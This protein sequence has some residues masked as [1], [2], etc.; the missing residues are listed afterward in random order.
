MISEQGAQ[1]VLHQGRQ[2]LGGDDRQGCARCAAPEQIG[3]GHAEA[4]P[5]LLDLMLDVTEEGGPVEA[6]RLSLLPDGFPPV[7]GLEDSL[8]LDYKRAI[9][10]LRGQADDESTEHVAA[11][12]GVLVGH[13]VAVPR[14]N[15]EVVK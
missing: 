14:V 10:K 9:G 1:L 12:W 2:R 11:A 3:H 7:E 15:V 8:V 6:R 5:N 13:E 4:S